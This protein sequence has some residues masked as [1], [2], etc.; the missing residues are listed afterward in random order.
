VLEQHLL[1]HAEAERGLREGAV[2]RHVAREQGEV[3]GART[4][5]PFA[6]YRIGRFFRVERRWSGATYFCSS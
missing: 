1:V 2:R 4:F 3:V 6:V 5:T